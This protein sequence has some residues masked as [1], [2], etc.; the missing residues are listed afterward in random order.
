MCLRKK[1]S[2]PLTPPKIRTHISNSIFFAKKYLA[3]RSS[4]FQLSTA[5]WEFSGILRDY[6]HCTSSGYCD[7][8]SHYLQGHVYSARCMKTSH[9]HVHEPLMGQLATP[10]NGTCPALGHHFPCHLPQLGLLK[11]LKKPHPVAKYRKSGTGERRPA[12]SRG[13][14]FKFKTN[15]S[16]LTSRFPSV[17]LYILCSK[18]SPARE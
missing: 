2:V 6:L 18:T 16:W 10:L 1:N 8:C 7:Y 12:L 3:R 15:T 9:R 5:H 13:G 4:E 11:G 17:E 14:D